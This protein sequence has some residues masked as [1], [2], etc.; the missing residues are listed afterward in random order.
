MIS[1]G[2]SSSKEYSKEY[3]LV[4]QCLYVLEYNG[5]VTELHQKKINAE[6]FKTEA[7]NEPVK[8]EL[9]ALGRPVKTQVGEDIRFVE[10]NWRI[11]RPYVDRLRSGKGQYEE[12]LYEVRHTIEGKE[13]RTLF[14]VY[15]DRMIL[16]HFFKKKTRKTPATDLDLGWN[17]MRKWVREQKD[18]ESKTRKHR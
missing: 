4:L 5:V 3:R 7:G 11:D 15:G 16:V 18:V 12:T 2:C 1:T 8:D 13:Y 14:F 10:I 6:F 9:K 17:R